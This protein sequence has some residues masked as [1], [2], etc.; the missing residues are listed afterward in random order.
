MLGLC[1][2][3]CYYLPLAYKKLKLYECVCRCLNY[4]R[5]NK[6]LKNDGVYFWGKII[7]LN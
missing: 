7:K 5:T 4:K 1:N 2:I 3:Y 6:I